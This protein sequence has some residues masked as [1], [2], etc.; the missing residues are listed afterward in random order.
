[1][2]AL[3]NISGEKI[4]IAMNIVGWPLE[5]PPSSPPEH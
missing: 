1:M 3:L 2:L 5:A 4:L